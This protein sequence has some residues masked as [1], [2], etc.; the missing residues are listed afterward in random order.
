MTISMYQ[1]SVP[2]FARALTNL[3]A[4]LAKADAHAQAKK[5]DASVFLNGRLAPDMLPLTKQVQIVSDNAKGTVAR[6]AGV[7]IP[8]YADTEATFEELLAR[9]DKTLAFVNSFKPAQI[10]GS[11]DRKVELKLGPNTVAFTGLSFLTGFALPNLYFHAVTAY[12][13]LRHLGVEIGKR[14]YIGNPQ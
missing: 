8:A 11:D 5:I 14:D 13:I 7:E 10:D 9:L 2:V 3:R 1:A 12:A 6:L 4:I